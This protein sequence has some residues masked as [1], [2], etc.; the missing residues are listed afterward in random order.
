MQRITEMQGLVY[1]PTARKFFIVLVCDYRFNSHLLS[2]CVQTQHWLTLSRCLAKKPTNI[3]FLTSIQKLLKVQGNLF[4]VSGACAIKNG[5]C[6]TTGEGWRK[7]SSIGCS[8]MCWLTLTAQ[9]KYSLSIFKTSYDHYLDSG[10][11][12]K[13]CS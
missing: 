9:G 12:L 1:Y 8:I 5:S 7:A 6:V 2:L 13:K 10:T 11:L 4:K 3:F